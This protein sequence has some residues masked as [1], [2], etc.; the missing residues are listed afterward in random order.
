M[1]MALSRIRYF[2]LPGAAERDELFLQSVIRESHTGLS[3]FAVVELF[4][5]ALLYAAPGHAAALALFIAATIAVTGGLSRLH[6]P[7][8]RCRW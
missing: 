2:L 3:Q 5:A 4:G 1:K 6:R 7:P 8:P